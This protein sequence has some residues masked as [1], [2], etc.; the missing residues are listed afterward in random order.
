MAINAED[1]QDTTVDPRSV[2]V[3]NRVRHR[4]KVAGGRTHIEQQKSD[5]TRVNIVLESECFT[6]V[7]VCIVSCSCVV[8]HLYRI[9]VFCVCNTAYMYIL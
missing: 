1:T 6:C 4:R 3:L 2:A 9:H 5:A 7:H 8:N